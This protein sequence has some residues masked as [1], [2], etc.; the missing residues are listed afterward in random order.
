MVGT[1]KGS[2]FIYDHNL[3]EIGKDTL[4]TFKISTI[5]LIPENPVKQYSSLVLIGDSLGKMK[6]IRVAKNGVESVKDTMGGH[7]SLITYA[8]SD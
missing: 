8:D 1:L 4:A 3:E 7:S 5:K 6:L 2:L